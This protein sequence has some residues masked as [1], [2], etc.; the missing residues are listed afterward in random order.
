MCSSTDNTIRHHSKLEIVSS[1][2]LR[3]MHRAPKTITIRCANDSQSHRFSTSLTEVI[4]GGLPLLDDDV[5]RSLG[6]EQSVEVACN[7]INAV[8]HFRLTLAGE[9]IRDPP[10]DSPTCKSSASKTPLTVLQSAPSPP[11]SRHASSFAGLPSI[12]SH[13]TGCKASR[14]VRQH[15]TWI[16]LHEAEGWL[17]FAIVC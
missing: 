13:P 5:R 6:Y 2:L 4:V 16:Y 8:N 10:K 17:Y 1:I 7:T 9:I 12:R 11:H 3:T 14:F 15:A